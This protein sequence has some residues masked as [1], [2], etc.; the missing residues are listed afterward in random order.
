MPGL[1]LGD[2]T[3]EDARSGPKG[4]LVVVPLG[5]LEQHGPHLPL[6]TDTILASYVAREAAAMVRADPPVVVAP[7]LAYG[8]SR[9]HL[10]YGGTS[11]FDSRDFYSCLVD[12]CSSLI[13]SGFSHIF[14]LNGHGGNHDLACTVPRD[15]V[16][17]HGGRVGAGSYWRMAEAQLLRAGAAEVGEIPGHAGAFETSLMLAVRPAL[18][19]QPLPVVRGQ[20]APYRVSSEGT[21]REAG[22]GAFRAPDGYS[23]NP[24]AATP[25]L[26]K[27]FAAICAAAA[28]DSLRDFFDG[29]RS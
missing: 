7:A 6:A 17:Q 5:S 1:K 8:V 26:G 9:H 23:D 18:V 2:I 25:S 3:R 12:I 13:Q 21:Y 4:R 10:S 20:G 29:W 16:L 19:V 14:L 11:S 28:A 24:S 22:P 15:V 27:E